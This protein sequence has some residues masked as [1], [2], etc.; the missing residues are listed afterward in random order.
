MKSKKHSEEHA[1]KA[2]TSEMTYIPLSDCKHGWLYE[3]RSRNLTLGVFRSDQK[4]FVGIR[5]K[6]GHVYLFVEFHW[7]TGAPFGTVKPLRLIERCPIEK[8]DEF[9][10]GEDG[11]IL[12]NEELFNWLKRKQH[13]AIRNQQ[14]NK[15]VT[16]IML[17]KRKMKPRMTRKKL[18]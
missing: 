5:E 2:G 12:E 15:K 11:K 14:D 18:G 9:F 13:G 17:P 7:D 1:E 16:A 10:R 6:L 3:I 4:G 8:L